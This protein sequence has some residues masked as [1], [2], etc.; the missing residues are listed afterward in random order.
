MAESLHAG[1][2][3]HERTTVVARFTKQPDTCHVLVC[4]YRVGSVGLNLQNLCHINVIFEPAVSAPV[5]DQAI[6]RTRRLHQK[7]QQTTI[8]LN[9]LGTFN[10]WQYENQKRKVIPGLIAQIDDSGEVQW[11]VED[12]GNVHG[13]HRKVVDMVARLQ[14]LLQGRHT[15][16]VLK[17]RSS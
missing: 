9:Q 4:S 7:Y 15:R 10:E 12:Q 3:D 17:S 5:Q 6:F 2:S 1:L 11:N 14:Q 8:L 13:D 16:A